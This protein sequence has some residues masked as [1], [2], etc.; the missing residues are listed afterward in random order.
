MRIRCQRVNFNPQTLCHT[1]KRKY[2]FGYCKKT[3]NTRD[4]TCCWPTFLSCAGAGV[5]EVHASLV[6]QQQNAQSTRGVSHAFFSRRHNHDRMRIWFS[7]CMMDSVISFLAVYR[8]VAG[9]FSRPKKSCRLQLQMKSENLYFLL[10][11]LS[12]IDAVHRS[13]VRSWLNSIADTNI[14]K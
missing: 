4:R 13:C 3:K 2:V 6:R 10:S 9:R 12:I 11:N 14:S 8:F 7:F 5:C 1:H